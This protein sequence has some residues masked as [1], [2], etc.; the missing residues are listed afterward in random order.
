M[1]TS[2]L[3]IKDTDLRNQVY[4]YGVVP[5]TFGLMIASVRPGRSAA[6]STLELIVY[7]I[8][9]S[10][11]SWLVQDLAAR[12]A[13]W[14]TASLRPTLIQ[15]LILGCIISIPL[16]FLAIYSYI[17][18][19]QAFMLAPDLAAPLPRMS[20]RSLMDDYAMAALVWI[21]FNYLL[22]NQFGISRFGFAAAPRQ[23]GAAAPPD[24]V[25]VAAGKIGQHVEPAFFSH[26]TKPIGTLLALHAEQHYLKVIGVDHSEM[27]RYRISD[28]AA[29]LANYQMGLQ[30]HRSWWVARDAVKQYS[31]NGREL[32]L[33]LQNGMEV[34]VSRTYR[35]M[36][37]KAGLLRAHQAHGPE[38]R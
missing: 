24:H 26:L 5:I 30:V 15:V 1:S 32:T 22:V 17:W 12:I 23:N 14:A 21:A 35:A 2:L 7:W 25:V 34:P 19:F 20:V 8:G 38:S 11:L 37:K 33:Q 6:W 27:I 36:A 28:A 18:F 29:E 3:T 13:R 9:A 31:R 10:L 16:T 4:I